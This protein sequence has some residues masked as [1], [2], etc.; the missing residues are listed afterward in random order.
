MSNTLRC[1]LIDDDPAAHLV[2]ANYISRVSYL[3]LVG[4]STDSIEAL[5]LVQQLKPDIL[6]LDVE[7]PEVTGMDFIKALPAPYP[8]IVMVTGSPQFA[9]ETYNFDIAHYLLK[10]VR[11]EK[12]IQAVQRIVGRLHFIQ[13]LTPQEPPVL[14]EANTP[15]LDENMVEVSKHLNESNLNKSSPYFLIKESKKLIRVSPDEIVFIEGMKDYL[16][17]HLDSRVIVAHMTMARLE[18]VL[19]EGQFLR[20]N[21]SYI[22]RRQAIKEIDGNRI[23]TINGKIVTIGITYRETIMQELKRNIL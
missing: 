7:M 19:P 21:R 17:L 10:P 2:I 8:Q 16:K 14:V 1:F 13:P 18:D 15:V 23:V 5:L 12:F 20:V 9:A 11:F 6:F 22:V 3:E 4:Q